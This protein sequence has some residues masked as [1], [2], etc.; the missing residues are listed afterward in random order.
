VAGTPDLVEAFH[1]LEQAKPGYE[2]ARD[3]YDGRVGEIFASE[4]IQQLLA[5]SG[6]YQIDEYNYARIPVDA[7][8]NR[9]AVTSL[10]VVRSDSGDSISGDQDGDQPE[11]TGEVSDDAGGAH[12]ATDTGLQAAQ[13][14]LNRLWKRNE[15][16]AE[17]LGL[18][19]DTGRDGDG[20]L[21]VWPVTDDSGRV[22]DVDMVVQDPTQVRVI[23]DSETPIRMAYAIKA[24]EVTDPDNDKKAHRANLYYSDRIERWTTAGGKTG[25]NI[26]DW[27]PYEGD[28]EDDTRGAEIPNPYGRPPFFHFRTARP[29]GTPDHRGGYGPQVLINKLVITHAATVDFLGFPQRYQMMDP[30]ADDPTSNLVD[31]LHPFDEIEDPED[32]GAVS[33]L[34]AD[35]GAVW[36]IWASAVGQFE[37][38]NPENFL[39]PLERHIQA[40]AELTDTPRSAFVKTTDIPSGA[41][42]REMDSPTVNKA[43]N[44]QERYGAEL[45]NALESALRML[46]FDNI[47]VQIQWKPVRTVSDSEGWGVVGQKINLGVPVREALIETGYEPE[48][49]D[50]W[51][52]DSEGA[53]LGRRVAL[54]N[55]IGTAVQ[56][57]GAGIALGVLSQEEAHDVV[58][59]VLQLAQAGMTVQPTPTPPPPPPPPAAGPGGGGGGQP[60]PTFQDLQR[61]A[62][63]AARDAQRQ[64]RELARQN[65]G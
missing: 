6:V 11:P 2:R 33:H 30:K 34:S 25:K 12:T 7:V 19:R 65:G 29:Y 60:P 20:Y 1:D 22:V 41:S 63:Y 42:F 13:Q 57:I 14:A 56:T 55:Q 37:P 44:R 18:F 58:S 59:R 10:R 24:W 40:M 53:D 17:S 61:Q 21:L 5:R 31:P 27:R 64:Q 16:D 36:K 48:T 4:R 54:L 50:Q 3:F 45:E 8:A 39:Q 23:Y 38:A 46:G 35:P 32:P 9:L 52:E 28:G 47:A 51:I 26:E 15:L 49:V 62:Q 43:Q